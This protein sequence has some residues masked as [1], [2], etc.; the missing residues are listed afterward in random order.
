MVRNG[1]RNRKAQ[2]KHARRRPRM[3]F[4]TRVLRAMEGETKVAKL[5][6]TIPLNNT[7]SDPR[8]LMPAIR[9]GTSAHA[10]RIGNN[11]SLKKLVIKGFI[12]IPSVNSVAGDTEHL[13]RLM[14]LRQRNVNASTIIGDPTLFA[15][16]DLMEYDQPYLGTPNNFLQKVNRSTFVSRKDKKMHFSVSANFQGNNPEVPNPDSIRFFSHTITFGKQGKSLNY[17]TDTSTTS[18][19]FPYILGAAIHQT[20]GSITAG[21]P[22][23]ELY[24]EAYYTD[25]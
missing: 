22:D 14:I 12:R 13:G 10:E 4:K 24:T 3:S 2:G 19:D 11:I 18:Q 9:Q 23:M 5:Y 25:M 20:D 6:Q 15:A 8:Q 1:K 7:I 16:N 17:Q 21:N